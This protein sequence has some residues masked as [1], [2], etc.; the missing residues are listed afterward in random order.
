MLGTNG[1]D[2][3][4][5]SGRRRRQR[6]AAVV[7]VAG[8]VAALVA[9]PPGRSGATPRSGSGAFLPSQAIGHAPAIPVGSVNL[10][11]TP[12]SSTVSFDVVLAPRSA[13]ALQALA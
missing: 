7:G 11:P 9:L 4:R 10:G 13:A 8:L 3:G 6:A 12:S 5:P 2:Q 1:S